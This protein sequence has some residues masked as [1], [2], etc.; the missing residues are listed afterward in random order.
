MVKIEMKRCGST[1]IL[2]MEGH[3]G[4][5]DVGHDIVC[6]AASILCY[7]AA[8][9][10]LDL[11]AAGKL[12]KQPRTDVEKGSATIT[13]CPKREAAAEI[14]VM[15]KTIETGFSLLSHHYSEYVSFEPFITGRMPV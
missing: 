1:Y 5:G 14:L 11:H 6:A 15:L 3:A 13:M 7:T 12:R 4:A 9:S 8:Q 2:H 10:A